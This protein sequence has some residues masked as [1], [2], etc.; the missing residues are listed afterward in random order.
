[1]EAIA[2]NY[3]ADKPSLIESNMGTI[4]W[5]SDIEA[6][7]VMKK[8]SD[9]FQPLQLEKAWQGSQTG[10]KPGLS[11]DKPPLA[12]QTSLITTRPKQSLRSKG[13]RKQ[14]PVKN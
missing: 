2:S 4:L 8:N 7:L 5:V 14:R 13:P 1:M 10:V 11:S 6:E 9:I 3:D 12:K